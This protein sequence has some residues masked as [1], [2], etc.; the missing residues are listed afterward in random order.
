MSA[1]LNVLVNQDSN[2]DGEPITECSERD[3]RRSSHIS[4][5]GSERDARE[6]LA[7]NR[8]TLHELGYSSESEIRTLYNRSTGEAIGAYLR[9]EPKMT[10]ED[11][12]D[13]LSTMAS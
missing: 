4:A 11:A 8:N 2:G 1:A 3:V 9:R 5:F 12:S 7:N 10:A 6:F 13:A